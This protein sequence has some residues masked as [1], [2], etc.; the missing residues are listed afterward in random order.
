MN[1]YSTKTAQHV[2]CVNWTYDRGG[3]Y[4][5][6]I[7]F[8]G[9]YLPGAP[10]SREQ[11]LAQVNIGNRAGH[12]IHLP[13][14]IRSSYL[15]K[16]ATMIPTPQQVQDE[17]TALHALRGGIPPKTGFGDDNLA[18][19]DAQIDVLTYQLTDVQIVDKYGGA[20]DEVQ[21]DAHYACRWLNGEAQDG[22]MSDNWRP[23]VGAEVKPIMR[24]I[25]DQEW[26][27]TSHFN[28]SVL[29]SPPTLDAQMKKPKRPRKKATRPTKKTIHARP[30]KKAKRTAPKKKNIR[31]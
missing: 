6:R 23:L 7:L 9:H 22:A 3:H 28:R 12:F 2:A 29:S 25:T 30:R 27:E 5:L 10:L 24:E 15:N 26:P 17:I 20:P 11:A 16:E 19:I 18:K 21:E 31:H 1:D 8:A 4:E 13:K 14:L